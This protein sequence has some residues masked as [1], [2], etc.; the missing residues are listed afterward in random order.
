MISIAGMDKAEVLMKLWNAATNINHGAAAAFLISL[1]PRMTID[2][3]R[4]HIEYAR[5]LPELY[6][7]YLE[8]VALKVNL[9]GDELDPRLYDRDNGEGAAAR[10]LGV[11]PW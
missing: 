3:A 5:Q 2:Q 4:G 8:G 6:F 1:Q 9:S 11:E 10:A 7:D